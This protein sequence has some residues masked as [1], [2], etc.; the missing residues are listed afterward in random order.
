M[1]TLINIVEHKGCYFKA[2]I[3]LVL[4]LETMHYFN[5]LKLTT[6]LQG[7]FKKYIYFYHYPSKCVKKSNRI[8]L[9]LVHLSSQPSTKDWC[10]IA[11][12]R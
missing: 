11:P 3:P 9:V 4:G 5:E 7:F 10:Y 2:K 1:K 8:S 6:N 12:L